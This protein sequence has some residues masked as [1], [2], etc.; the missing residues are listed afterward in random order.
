MSLW[1]IAKNQCLPAKRKQDQEDVMSK[2]RVVITGMGIKS[3]I[4]N[5]LDEFWSNICRGRHGI[6]PIEF[7]DA[8]RLS[9]H[10]AAYD[11]DFDPAQYFDRK[12]L[13]RTDRFCQFAVAASVDAAADAGDLTGAYDPFRVGVIFSSGIGGFQTI[14]REHC[15]CL[16]KGPDRVSVFF[17]PMMISNIAAGMI[18]MRTGFKGANMSI[19]TACASSNNALGEAFHK[20]RDGYLDA[21]VVGGA[22]AGIGE[23]TMAGFNNMTALTRSEDPD[24]ASIPFDKQRNGFVMGEGAGALVIE[25]L[26]SAK[27]RGAKIYAEVAGYGAT[28]DAYHITKPD[29]SAQGPSRCFRMAIEDAG[30][31]P[32]Q[33]DYINA[34]GTS[35]P[36][37]EVTETKA[38]KLAFGEHAYQ[39][40]V[41]STK[42][43]TGHMLGAAGAAEGIVCAMALHDG[44]VPP[45]VGYRVPDEECDLDYVT[46]GARRAEIRAALS[47]S[48]GFGGHNAAVCFKKYCE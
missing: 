10:V 31:K 24:R 7:F 19:V 39:M 30:L 11:Y 16:E 1:A 12:E 3:C 48:L 38:I 14:E 28:G 37:N 33:I 40:A 2:R 21:C 32:E 47:N 9:V 29:P 5:T 23:L 8:S 6:R 27:K 43:M 34:H 18:S 17:I 35:T 45:T 42:S 41:S 44:V 26:E 4:G 46:Q 36:A 13:R 25:E 20:V 15:K 22:E